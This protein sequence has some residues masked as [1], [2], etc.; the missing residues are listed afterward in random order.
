MTEP[1][2]ALRPVWTA[3]ALRD[4]ADPAS[5]R[6]AVEQSLAWL[7]AQPTDLALVMGPRRVTVA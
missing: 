5:L 1:A 6:A 3:P 2:H 4:D 7:A